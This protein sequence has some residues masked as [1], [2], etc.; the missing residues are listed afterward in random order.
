MAAF[1]KV[2][3]LMSVAAAAAA[4]GVAAYDNDLV[5]LTF[6]LMMTTHA[7]VGWWQMKNR[8]YDTLVLSG[9]MIVSVAWL[10][11]YGGTS[12]VAI[13]LAAATVA[14]LAW[15]FASGRR[16]LGF[17][18][19]V[20]GIWLAQALSLAIHI[21]E[22]GLA[23]HQDQAVGIAMQA[24]M[25][26]LGA[27]LVGKV[28]RAARLSGNLYRDV[29]NSA[30]ISIWREDFS[31]VQQWTEG[32]RAAGVK[33]LRAHLENS[34][35]LLAEAIGMIEVVDVNPAG[36][37]LIGVEDRDQ[38]LGH[39]RPET[40]GPETL[41]A[42]VDQLMAVWERR[43]HVSTEVSG[44]RVDGTPFSAM[45][46]WSASG[47][48]AA[49]DLST[50]IVTIDDISLLKNTQAELGKSGALMTALADAQAKYIAGSDAEDVWR[51][52][53]QSLLVHTD[54]DHAYLVE[55][56]F[57]EPASSGPRYRRVQARRLTESEGSKRPDREG[58]SEALGQLVDENVP[59]VYLDGEAAADLDCR[60]LF[61]VPIEVGDTT[62][63]ALVLVNQPA[64]A[65]IDDPDAL[66]PFRTTSANLIS[67]QKAERERAAIEA[68]LR[69][70]DARLRAVLAGVPI[71]VM[72]INSGGVVTLA[73]GTGLKVL[74]IDAEEAVG[75]SA[76]DL[77]SNSRAMLDQIRAAL[78]GE[79]ASDLLDIEGYTF[80]TSFNP[81]GEFDEKPESIIGVATDLT[82]R[83]RIETELAES[84]ERFRVLIERV[85]DLIYTVDAEGVINFIAPSVAE[86]L[87]YA[88]DD[89]V[90]TRIHDL[91]HE[92]DLLDVRTAIEE[93]EPGDSSGT[94]EHRL[95]HS[96]GT[97]RHI[98]VAATNLLDDPVIRGWLI[99]GRDITARRHAERI[100]RESEAS[101]RLLAENS[102]DLISRHSIDGTYLYASPAALPML[103]YT[104]DE[105]AGRSLYDLVHPDD[106]AAVR[107]EIEAL[108]DTPEVVTISYRCQRQSGSYTW[109]ESTSRRMVD[110]L[111][112]KME[113]QSASRDISERK[114]FE[115]ALKEARDAAEAA[116]RVKSQFLANMSHEIRTPMNAIVGMT[117]LSLATELTA[118]QREYLGTIK[119]SVDALLELINDVLDVSKI[120]AGHLEFER[121]GFSLSDVV[122]DTVRTL[123]VKA[124]EKGLDLSFHLNEG[125][126]DGVIGDPG[127]LRQILVNLVGNAIKFSHIG[128]VTVSVSV[129]PDDQ[130]MLQ[131]DVSDTG[132]GIG[133]DKL[134]R[135][136]DAFSQADGS[137][138]RRYGGT[139]LGLSISRDIAVAMGGNL[140]VTSTVGEGSTFTF[141][142]PLE[143]FDDSLLTPVGGSPEHQ[144][145]LVIADSSS[146]KRS[147]AEML[148][149]AKM[150]PVLAGDLAEATLVLEQA[151]SVGRSPSVAV[152]DQQTEPIGFLKR[153]LDQEPFA[154]IQPVVIAGSG[155]RGDAS[156]LR[157]AGAAAYLTKPF[158]P[159]ELLETIRAVMAGSDEL[160]TKHWIRERRHNVN[161]LLADDSPTNRRLAMRL[162]EKRGHSVTS[163]ENGLQAVQAMDKDSYDVIL[164]D[165]QMPVMDGLEAA[166]TIREAEKLT[167]EHIP[168]I[169]LTAHAMKGDRERCLEA[170]MDAYVSKPFQAEELFATIEQ[171]VNFAAAAGKSVELKWKPLE[172]RAIDVEVAL[173]RLGGIPDLLPEVAQIFLDEYPPQLEDLKEA[174]AA[175][176]MS[177]IAKVAHRLK[178][179]L[180]TL[181]AVAAHEA[182]Q[183]VVSLAR[184][185]DHEAVPEACERFLGEMERVHPEL[186][187]LAAGNIAAD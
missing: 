133:P 165:V 128:S 97:W 56:G 32:L 185:E 42:F 7:V 35:D 169:A 49:M 175:G 66:L 89:L 163:V 2:A 122:E 158:E 145:V 109:F 183:T 96:D 81:F 28:T 141:T 168:I 153:M 186:M 119:S 82:D 100:L 1:V 115:A 155:H 61:A 140:T 146:I 182:S 5:W 76:F 64:E 65:L 150:H 172:E 80:A 87:G 34:P 54:A 85:S 9:M 24:A 173:S 94:V 23:D 180:G 51:A 116:T 138:T 162:L 156:R 19:L 21:N 59:S 99:N 41:P 33:D 26:T 16:R 131:F 44:R 31:R 30:P 136:F 60:N 37:A 29:I 48:E 62:V 110:P 143:V 92:D 74:G 137:M 88:P 148:R 27:L 6:G 22:H 90:G 121:T 149:Q 91:I 177:N 127:R 160:V 176:D 105:L 106:L 167:G 114:E 86:V 25:F 187:L 132:I 171:L 50:V 113:I 157:A 142:M 166:Q 52:I 93:V 11:T 147:L 14:G 12:S 129:D 135:I 117:E 170:G 15:M 58:L 10:V 63:G 53:L 134:E 36:L 164:M 43:A 45:L 83:M 144:T 178:G 95:R 152:I 71:S 179:E 103:G 13:P 98:E 69:E 17:L 75:R 8:Q 118:E 125:V 20:G 38:M 124:A 73:S 112:G 123:A 154:G 111:T 120:E 184:A 55:F 70:A 47:G 39:L 108:L 3:A 174:L 57:G 77:F 72:M 40:I 104:T 126:P 159:G 102:T 130:A 107:A 139:G 161:V 84:Q 79:W 101:F 181:G 68:E 4:F 18:G 78:E 151:A 67:A 46:H